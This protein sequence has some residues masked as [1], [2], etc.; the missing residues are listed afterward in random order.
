[1]FSGGGWAGSDRSPAV[2]KWL[3]PVG[4]AGRGCWC[5]PPPL[6]RSEHW[7]G[8][9]PKHSSTKER[10]VC[11]LCRGHGQC[12]QHKPCW[13]FAQSTLKHSSG[14]VRREAWEGDTPAPLLLHSCREPCRKSWC[15]G[16][17]HGEVGWHPISSH[18]HLRA[19]VPNV[20]GISANV[21]SSR[22]SLCPRHHPG[23]WVCFAFFPG[24]LF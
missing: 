13:R 15:G 14:A 20:R 18:P 17:R 21:C 4:C 8:V 23:T 19:S 12:S 3:V 7:W 24:G 1:M 11:D 16:E 22:A 9:A 10:N 6:L 2:G 5:P